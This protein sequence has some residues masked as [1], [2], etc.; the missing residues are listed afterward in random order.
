MKKGFIIDSS[1]NVAIVL[2]DIAVGETVEI[3]A[4]NVVARDQIPAVHKIAIADISAGENV[5]KF[6][7]AIGKAKEKIQT[8]D[9]VHVHNLFC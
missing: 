8:G 9:W 2:E 7:D 6:G 3:G 4:I 1:D 5:R